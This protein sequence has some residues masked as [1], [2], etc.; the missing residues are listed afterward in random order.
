M[1]FQLVTSNFGFCSVDA[2]FLFHLIQFFVPQELKYCSNLREVMN[3]FVV[4]K[5][6]VKYMVG[7]CTCTPYSP[8]SLYIR[9]RKLRYWNTCC[10]PITGHCG[11]YASVFASV[12]A[13]GARC[14]PLVVET[15]RLFCK[16]P[17]K[18]VLLFRSPS[19]LLCLFPRWIS[20]RISFLPVCARSLPVEWEGE[21]EPEL[22]GGRL[23]RGRK[24]W[25]QF[26]RPCSGDG[27]AAAVWRQTCSRIWLVP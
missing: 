4:A 11:P 8:R 3:Y 21:A 1:L 13:R 25:W 27:A 9:I 22:V 10:C 19:T 7:P 2:K 17:R 15:A 14:Q 26:R 23:G 12:D 5:V 20:V 16:S 6:W 24:S 18:D